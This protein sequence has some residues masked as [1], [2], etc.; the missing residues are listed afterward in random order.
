MRQCSCRKISGKALRIL[1]EHHFRDIDD[2]H[3]S[4]GYPCYACKSKGSV[5]GS[6][7]IALTGD[8]ASKFT[9]SS[10]GGGARRSLMLKGETG[11]A[12]GTE[13]DAG[14]T[15]KLY[16]PEPCMCTGVTGSVC[17]SEPDQYPLPGLHTGRVRDSCAP[18]DGQDFYTI[19]THGK[20][21]TE[22]T[23]RVRSTRSRL[24][25][26]MPK[27]SRSWGTRILSRH[28]SLWWPTLLRMIP[29]QKPPTH[30]RRFQHKRAAYRNIAGQDRG[31]PGSATE[32]QDLTLATTPTEFDAIR[33]GQGQWQPGA[34]G[35]SRSD[36][37]GRQDIHGGIYDPESIMPTG[38]SRRVH[39]ALHPD[40]SI[41]FGEKTMMPPLTKTPDRYS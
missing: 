30:H 6:G 35:E 5:T 37:G 23:A 25:F 3:S 39:T 20:G 2:Q 9:A 24:S 34:V 40:Y 18:G 29:I 21:Q 15:S 7:A 32:S 17:K 36:H 1:D 28:Q 11:N 16:S 4:H 33:V 31:P 27:P 12:V 22:F 26:R 14:A 13:I 8:D 10:G 41:C 19:F 38:V